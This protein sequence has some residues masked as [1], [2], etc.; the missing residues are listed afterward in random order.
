MT[1]GERPPPLVRP[2][3]RSGQDPSLSCL[4]GAQG[5]LLHGIRRASVLMALLLATS[6][7]AVTIMGAD[8]LTRATAQDRISGSW[9]K[10]LD[11]STPSFW[12]AGSLQRQGWFASP[13][14]E[15]RPAP[16]IPA[17]AWDLIHLEASCNN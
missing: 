5:E 13:A 4:K 3:P 16:F 8:I 2:V 14:V 11:L 9:I 10:A 15:L 7:L 6:L 1:A 17:P 12:P